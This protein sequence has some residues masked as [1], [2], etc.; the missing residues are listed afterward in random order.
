MF[1]A[2][3][4]RSPGVS[5][6]NPPAV[7]LWKLPPM[8]RQTFLN[9]LGDSWMLS[10]P[11]YQYAEFQEIKLGEQMPLPLSGLLPHYKYTPVYPDL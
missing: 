11:R 3:L 8:V 6:P 7:A 9:C 10:L 5:Y 1:L 2:S 4:V